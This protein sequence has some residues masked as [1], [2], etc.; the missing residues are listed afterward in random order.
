MRTRVLRILL[1]VCVAALAVAGAAVA[2]RRDYTI[3]VLNATGGMIEYFYY[4]ECRTDSW[5]G[6]RLGRSEVIAPGARRMFDM[7]D[8]IADCCRDMRAKFSNGA[9]RHW[10]GVNVCRESAWIVR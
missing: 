1:A 7:Y 2:Q 3:T 10:M 8:N 5:H 9:T 6:D 4:S